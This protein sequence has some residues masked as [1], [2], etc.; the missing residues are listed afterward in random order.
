M[1]I[2]LIT[3]G[4]MP[5]PPNGWGAI[6]LITWEYKLGL[7]KLGHHVD[8]LWLN[9]VTPDYDIVHVHSCNLAHLCIERGIPYVFSFHDHH[10]ISYGR[11]NWQH[12]WY[13]KAFE[14]SEF[15]ICPAEWIVDYFACERL[16]FLSHGVNTSFF[17]PNGKKPEK[18]KLLCIASNGSFGDHTIDRKG[19]RY[20]IEAARHLDLDITVAGPSNNEIFFEAHPDLQYEKLVKITDNPNQE[21]VRELNNNH[22]IFLHPSSIETGHPNLTIL[23]AISCGTPVVG[24]YKGHQRIEGLYRLEEPST[25]GVIR[26]IEEVISNY[27]DYCRRAREDAGRFD[28]SIFVKQLSDMY[29]SARK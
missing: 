8:I 26:G 21:M 7:E 22:S 4:G 28:W 2:A 5:I 19:F 1:K 29:E 12:D 20:A 23:E 6:E 13:V 24:T 10:P 16:V 9:D 18:T 3:N 17:T 25:E 14:N 27:D 11:E 15:S